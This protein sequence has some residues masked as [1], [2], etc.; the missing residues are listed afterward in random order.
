MP[1]LSH[2]GPVFCPVH[3]FCKSLIIRLFKSQIF[4]DTSV[5]RLIRFR[6]KVLMDLQ[7][8]LEL[9]SLEEKAAQV[10]GWP[11]RLSSSPF[12]VLSETH[13]RSIRIDILPTFSIW[14]LRTEVAR[15]SQ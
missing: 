6:Q 11:F 3:T 2:F 1:F 5:L 9:F 4:L 15:T 10:A 7:A 14:E 8:P 12:P 13:E